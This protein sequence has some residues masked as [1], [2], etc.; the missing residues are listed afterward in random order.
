[1]ISQLLKLFSQPVQGR[2][3]SGSMPALPLK[4]EPVVRLHEL[5]KEFLEAGRVRTVLDSVNLSI[6]NGEFV[7]LLGHS[8]SGKSTLLNLISGIEKPTSG[9][10]FI[11]GVPITSFRERE[12]TLFRRDQIWFTEK[13][14]DGATKLYP[15]TEY[16][17][18]K[19]EALQKGYLCGRYGAI[20]VLEAFGD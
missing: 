16:K 14:E 10:I 9:S 7:V 8:G 1:M 13:G 11:H 20:P 12:R 18:R 2:R 4:E 17:P 19:R 5:S 6:C 15:L 3:S